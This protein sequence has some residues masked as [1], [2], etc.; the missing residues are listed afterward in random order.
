MHSSSEV[1]RFK[2]RIELDWPDI[3]VTPYVVA[4]VVLPF[5]LVPEPSIHEHFTQA[6]STYDYT[7][8]TELCGLGFYWELRI[9]CKKQS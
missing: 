1:W 7:L 5:R 4:E 6:Q 8:H 9:L 2:R 3:K